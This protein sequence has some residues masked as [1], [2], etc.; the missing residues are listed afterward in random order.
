[1]RDIVDRL[2]TDAGQLTI[3]SLIQEREAAASEI[4]RLR[5]TIDRLNAATNVPSG[6]RGK[7]NA[8][9]SPIS[10]SQGGG[11]T[12]PSASGTLLR[13]REVC[14]LLAVSRSTIYQWVADGRF[15]RPLRLSERSV[16]WRFS[17]IESWRA[18]LDQK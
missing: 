7:M 15:P 12:P 18:E 1:M 4:E 16:R 8:I 3:A 17:D 14:R 9:N 2:R 10:A 6:R 13:L 11:S 5:G